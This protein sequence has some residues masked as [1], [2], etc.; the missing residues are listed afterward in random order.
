MTRRRIGARNVV[1]FCEVR[2]ANHM[3]DT[4]EE[5][6]VEYYIDVDSAGDHGRAIKPMIVSRMG[7]VMRQSLTAEVIEDMEADDLIQ[8]VAYHAAEDRDFLLPD[9]PLKESVFRVLLANENK[10]MTAE[11]V[12]KILEDK[13]SLSPYPRDTSPRVIERLLAGGGDTYCFIAVPPPPEE[14]PEAAGEAVDA[15]EGEAEGVEEE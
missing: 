11:Q 14:E 4:G 12:S 8:Q 3:A 15:V 13:W 6:A 2:D 5:K 7:Y 10:P 1:Q 9:T